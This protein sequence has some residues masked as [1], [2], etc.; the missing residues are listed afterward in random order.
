MLLVPGLCICQLRIFQFV[1]WAVSGEKCYVFSPRSKIVHFF[2]PSS[3][4]LAQVMSNIFMFCNPCGKQTGDWHDPSFRQIH[5]LF[6]CECHKSMSFFVMWPVNISQVPTFPGTS[7]W[8][9]E[10]V[11]TDTRS[12]RP[13][14]IY[15]FFLFKYIQFS[16]KWYSTMFQRVDHWIL[17]LES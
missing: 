1:P 12:A 2:S 10:N 3:T 16:L 11:V 7:W 5:Q 8:H 4:V 6:L 14:H 15:F 9:S 17:S 13:S